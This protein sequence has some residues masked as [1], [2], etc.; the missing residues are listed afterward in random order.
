VFFW[1]LI[2]CVDARCRHPFPSFDC[3]RRPAFTTG[4]PPFRRC[5]VAARQTFNYASSIAAASVLPT[6]ADGPRTPFERVKACPQADRERVARHRTKA[7]AHLEV[8]ESPSEPE[9]G[10]ATGGEN[11]TTNA[12]A[13][14]LW[15]RR[16][17]CELGN[18]FAIPTFP[19]P[20]QQQSFGYITN[21]STT[22]RRV[23]FSN[24]LTG[25]GNPIIRMV[26]PTQSRL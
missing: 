14:R 12:A 24:V 22:P 10:A 15:K 19:Q 21:V 4:R 11:V 1:V 23:T 9:G 25:S 13:K 5:R 17:L 6:C 18:R 20:Q 26:Q 8:G 2:P 16:S 3:H 7:G